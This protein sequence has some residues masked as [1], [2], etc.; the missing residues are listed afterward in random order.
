MTLQLSCCGKADCG[1]LNDQHLRELVDRTRSAAP[2]CL[3][4]CRYR[5]ACH[6]GTILI[7]PIGRADPAHVR[8]E[9]VARKKSENPSGS[10]VSDAGGL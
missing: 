7:K 6:C 5:S 3:K 2:A 4:V 10:E 8:I 1:A 9:D